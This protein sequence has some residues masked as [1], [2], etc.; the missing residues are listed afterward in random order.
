MKFGLINRT[1]DFYVGKLTSTRNIK[2][3]NNIIREN[4]WNMK[5]KEPEVWAL[6]F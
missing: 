2:K 5:L 4:I 3:D 6:K 1:M